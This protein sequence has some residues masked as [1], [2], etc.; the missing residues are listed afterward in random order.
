[1]HPCCWCDVDMNNLGKK[2][3]QRTIESLTDLF[4]RF[5]E[6]NEL[7]EKAKNYGNVIHLPIISNVDPSTPV[8]HVVPPPELHLLIGPVNHMNTQME[9]VW[10]ESEVLFGPDPNAG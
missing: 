3:N 7:K 5:F 6:S 1:M 4:W 8:I 10:E 2:G 9:K